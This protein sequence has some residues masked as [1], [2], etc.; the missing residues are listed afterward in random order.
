MKNSGK[1]ETKEVRKKY[2]MQDR[3]SKAKKVVQRVYPVLQL[4]AQVFLKRHSRLELL[5]S[6]FYTENFICRLF[7][8]NSI[9]ISTQFTREVGVTARNRKNESQ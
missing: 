1:K 9:V 4:R 3:K 2:K 6:V 8:F 7:W 5:K